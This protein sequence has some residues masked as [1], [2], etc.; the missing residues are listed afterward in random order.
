M[1][2]MEYLENLQKEKSKH[3][4]CPCLYVEP[5]STQCTCVNPFM[6]AGC[7]RCCRYGSEDQRKSKAEFL[8]KKIDSNA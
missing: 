7:N 1:S 3:G 8:A 5:C 6:S 2:Q 4:G